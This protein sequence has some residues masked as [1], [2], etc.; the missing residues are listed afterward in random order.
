MPWRSMWQRDQTFLTQA[1][2]PRPKGEDE[3]RLFP[4]VG[5][6]LCLPVAVLLS[7]DRLEEAGRLVPDRAWVA[8]TPLYG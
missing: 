5:G 6:D 8:S 7:R 1:R 3:I 4:I 2:E